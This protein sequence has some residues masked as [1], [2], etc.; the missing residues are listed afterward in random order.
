[1]FSRLRGALFVSTLSRDTVRE[2]KADETFFGGYC[3]HCNALVAAESCNGY[4]GRLQDVKRTCDA[5]H[6]QQFENMRGNTD[7]H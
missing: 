1:M 7:E 6:L 3:S 5:P 4:C 2:N